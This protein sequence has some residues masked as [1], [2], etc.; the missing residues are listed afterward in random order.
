MPCFLLL[1]QDMYNFSCYK[2]TLCGKT[3]NAGKLHYLLRKIK[4]M[5]KMAA[6]TAKEL[7][8]IQDQLG[9]EQNL[10]KKYHL[11]AQNAQDE[12]IR[13][14]CQK[15]SDSHQTHYNTLLGHLN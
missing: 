14:A 11:Y 8:A 3:V 6:I 7:N 13:A 5:K 2:K 12:Q 4:E 1:V 9:V 15:L 10:I